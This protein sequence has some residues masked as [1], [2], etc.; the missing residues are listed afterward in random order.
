M[1]VQQIFFRCVFVYLIH[2]SRFANFFAL[3]FVDFYAVLHLFHSILF[4]FSIFVF[5]C[6]LFLLL[7]SGYNGRQRERRWHALT[8]T[9]KHTHF[10]SQTRCS[11]EYFIIFA[12]A[13]VKRKRKKSISFCRKCTL[14]I[15]FL[16]LECVCVACTRA[17][18]YN[19]TL[20]RPRI[21]KS[22]V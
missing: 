12:V 15:G 21:P 1:R 20:L 17:I 7:L 9:H 18:F 2:P 19:T 10:Y 13:F 6:A 14:R 4:S 16:V 8:Y 22:E 3:V 5:I 11:R